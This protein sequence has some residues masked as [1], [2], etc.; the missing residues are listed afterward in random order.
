ML[1]KISLQ[2]VCRKT[3]LSSPNVNFYI[4]FQLCFLYYSAMF[5]WQMEMMKCVCVWCGVYVM[6][7]HVWNIR[8]QCLTGAAGSNLSKEGIFL[9]LSLQIY[10]M[11]TSDLQAYGDNVGTHGHKA[12]VTEDVPHSLD[13]V[14]L[15]QH[16]R[17]V[18]VEDCV[19]WCV[20]VFVCKCLSMCVCVWVF[21]WVCMCM[22]IQMTVNSVSCYSSEQ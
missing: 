22:C 12:Q 4:R 9:P 21:V 10:N 2:L 8:L 14:G 1:K 16:R 18:G 6:S 7:L 3:L 5:M 11:V 13:S 20:C 17:S 19:K 15:K